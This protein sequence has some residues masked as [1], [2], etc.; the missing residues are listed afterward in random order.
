M[1]IITNAKAVAGDLEAYEVR[2]FNNIQN[3]VRWSMLKI[4]ADA[5]DIIKR[6]D[7]IASGSLIS[8]ITSLVTRGID[9]ILGVTGS[10]LA[11]AGWVHDGT[12]PHFPPIGPIQEWVE[13]KMARGVLTT[14]NPKS[15]AFLI[16]RKISRVGTKGNPFLA[17]SLRSNRNAMV[18]RVA[19][20][21]EGAA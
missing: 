18:R 3:A 16:A 2:V 7:S 17:I 9:K 5:V 19:L 1:K 14:D 15:L 12:S 11:Y 13:T 4:E 6:R 10:N 8:S 21:I 20:A